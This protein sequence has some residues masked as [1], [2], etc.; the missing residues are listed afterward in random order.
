MN[1]LAEE[2][3]LEGLEEKLEGGRT[4][5][6]RSRSLHVALVARADDEETALEVRD[7]PTAGRIGLY[8]KHNAEDLGLERFSVPHERRLYY[9]RAGAD[10]PEFFEP[11]DEDGA[12]G[13]GR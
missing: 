5:F 6:T 11:V 7:V 8:L 10:V 2:A 9:A 3:L 13:G 12:G 4:V 1:D